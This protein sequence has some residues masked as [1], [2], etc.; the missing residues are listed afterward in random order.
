MKNRTPLEKNG[1][2][3]QETGL[4]TAE[5]GTW[6]DTAK[7][8]DLIA[9]LDNLPCGVS[10]LGSPFGKA[11]YINRQLL[12]TLGYSLVSEPTSR[13]MMRKAMP[14]RRERSAAYRSWKQVVKA[15][16]GTELF[17][18]RCSDGETRVFETW[19]VV[20]RKDLILNTWMDVTRR[21]EMEQQLKDSEARFRSFFEKST[22]PF[23]LFDGRVL[24]NCNFAAQKLFNCEN[25]TEIIGRTLESLSPERQADGRLTRKK[26]AA[27][28][29]GALKEGSHRTEWIILT[30]EK[31]MIP[32]EL[33]VA[34]IR[35]EEADLLFVVLRDI[36]QWKEAENVLRGAKTDLEAAV[37]ARTFEL[38]VVNE[39]LRSSREELRHL[40][41]YLQQAREE[42]RTRIAREV[43]D[44]VGQ[45]L[46]GLKMDLAYQAQNPPGQISDMVEQTK[47]VLDQI[48]GVIHS[49]QEI[50]SDLRP[51]IL[52][53]F[54]LIAAI[55]W[56]LEEFEK[57]TGIRCSTKTDS[58]LP[59]LHKD[60]DLLLFRVFQEAMANI[61]RHARATT[62]TVKLR[63]TGD[64]VTLTVKDNGRGILKEEAVHPRSF[65]IIGIRERVRFWGGKADFRGRP[66]RG[67][68]VIVSLPIN[69]SDSIRRQARGNLGDNRGSS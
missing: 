40:S 48:D 60:L 30:L 20:L 33:S 58:K 10:V 59:L 28:L 9:V 65:G 51:T 49:V 43:H 45:F 46:T 68:T 4:P 52:S 50:C 3:S 41:E 15:G 16:G 54:G 53:H 2:A 5:Q 19:T 57:R 37:K 26:A 62:V 44:R 42:E 32:V 69:N 25:K 14:C 35:I 24:V 29:R 36:T 64:T 55:G 67:T 7:R 1:T 63:C 38:T 6:I 34:V 17:P 21:R 47:L 27:L 11:R 39:E 56:Y 13:G 22:D 66:N 18:H 23:L 31:K 12:D 8:E 61:V